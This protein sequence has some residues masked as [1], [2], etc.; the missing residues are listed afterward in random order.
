[1]KPMCSSWWTNTFMMSSTTMKCYAVTWTKHKVIMC[2]QV[3]S[4]NVYKPIHWQF[5]TSCGDRKQILQLHW[6][7]GYS[8]QVRFSMT[9]LEYSKRWVSLKAWWDVWKW[10][11]GIF[12][13]A[14][15]SSTLAAFA[16]QEV[17]NLT[18]PF[19]IF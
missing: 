8:S 12:L 1:M 16:N 19:S 4:K 5:Q 2:M 7:I 10:V 11:L 6:F 18:L 14:S 17:W 15:V 9:D 3:C 13:W